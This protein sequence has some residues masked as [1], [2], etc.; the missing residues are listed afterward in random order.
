MCWHWMHTII[1]LF[2]R[3]RHDSSSIYPPPI[4]TPPSCTCGCHKKCCKCSC[5][6]IKSGTQRQLCFTPFRESETYQ[7]RHSR[8]HT[9]SSKD[10]QVKLITTCFYCWYNYVDTRKTL[11]WKATSWWQKGKTCMFESNYQW[12]NFTKR[13]FDIDTTIF[14]GYKFAN[15]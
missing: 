5:H 2:Y 14:F 13:F 12:W 11:F 3:V 1:L 15:F 8:V 9:P 10:F 7:K 4:H 6:V